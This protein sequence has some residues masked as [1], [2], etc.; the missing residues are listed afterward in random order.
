MI[1]LVGPLCIAFVAGCVGR[2]ETALSSPPEVDPA[3]FAACMAAVAPQSV[4]AGKQELLCTGEPS[5]CL[6]ERL[7][8]PACTAASTGPCCSLFVAQVDGGAFFGEC[9]CSPGAS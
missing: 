5:G 3:A 7:E 6:V 2:V 4:P 1:R 8:M 9:S